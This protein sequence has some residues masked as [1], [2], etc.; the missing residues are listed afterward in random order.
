MDPLPDRAPQ[1][2]GA[3]GNGPGLLPQSLAAGG[4]GRGFSPSDPP[5]PGGRNA[6]RHP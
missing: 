1:G 5:R 2:G 3:R 6:D 4:P